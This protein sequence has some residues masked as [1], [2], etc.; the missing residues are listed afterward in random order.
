MDEVFATDKFIYGKLS[1]NGP[2]AALVSTRIF[3][4]RAKAG[5]PF[6]Y[7]IFSASGT[8]DVNV[9]GRGSSR[10]ASR[11][12]YIIKAV[13]EDPDSY[14]GASA[15]AAAL[16]AAIETSEGTQVSGGFTFNIQC[17]GRSSGISYIEEDAET[18]YRHQGG[19]YSFFVSR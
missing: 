18:S 2:L 17:E 14:S 9:M 15:I 7:V 1:G 8:A 16:D 12:E 3:R 19:L 5:T 13:T 4:D 6:P 10:I 11:I